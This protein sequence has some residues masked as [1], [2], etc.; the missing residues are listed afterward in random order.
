MEGFVATTSPATVSAHWRHGAG[1]SSLYFDGDACAELARQVVSDAS[2]LSHDSGVHPPAHGALGAEASPSLRVQRFYY[3]QAGEEVC[4]EVGFAQ[5]FNGFG[6][7]WAKGKGKAAGRVCWWDDE[8]D[9]EDA[10]IPDEEEEEG[11]GNRRGK[12]RGGNKGKGKAKGQQ[13]GNGKGRGTAVGK[14]KAKPKPMPKSSSRRVSA[15]R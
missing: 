11:K 14:A 5:H 15:A 3:T 9:D 8:S 7:F 13:K 4:Y 1:F 10:T 12:G 2:F 6:Q